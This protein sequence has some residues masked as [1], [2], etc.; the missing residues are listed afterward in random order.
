MNKK[1]VILF[2]I[3]GLWLAPVLV[4][5]APNIPPEPRGDIE[6]FEELIYPIMKLLWQIFLVIF[7]V[8]L[9]VSAFLFLTALGDENKLGTARTALIW[10]I[11]SFVVAFVSF[12]LPY[13]LS[14]ALEGA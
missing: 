8:L 9:L 13:M 10:T 12:S 1:F 3:T 14:L 2:L 7:F 11:A 5:G 6:D 4:M